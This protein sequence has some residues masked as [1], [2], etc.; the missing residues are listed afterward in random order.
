MSKNLISVYIITFNE[1]DRINDTIIAA[2]KVADEII[3]IDSGSTDNT[4]IIAKKHNID[5][6]YNKWHSYC[7]QKYFAQNKCRNDW[8]LMIDA[9]EVISDQLAQEINQLKLD[10][11]YC[12]FKIKIRNILPNQKKPHNIIADY[13]VVRLYNKKICSMPQR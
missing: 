10:D 3:I 6:I 12:S 8:V 4:K 11:Q 13:N 1:Q 9:D 7:E 2:K 5:V